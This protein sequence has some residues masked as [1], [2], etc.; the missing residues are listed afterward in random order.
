[1]G[2]NKAD[3]ARIPNLFHKSLGVAQPKLQFYHPKVS[4]DPFL[5]MNLLRYVALL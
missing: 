3:F 2:I 4:Q 5:A 1:M